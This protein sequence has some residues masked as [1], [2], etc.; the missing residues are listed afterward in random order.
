[1]KISYFRWGAMSRRQKKVMSWW[2]K[3]SKYADY[4]GIICD[5]AIR[6]GKTVSMAFSFVLWAMHTY[7]RENFAM[8]GKTIA[9]FRRN[10]LGTLKRQLKARG[11]TVTEKRTENLIVVSK[12]NKANLFYIFGGKDESSQD[13]IQG[14]TLA[15][16]FC[17]E[18][19]LMPESFVNQATARCSVE[20]S[21]FWFNCNPEGPQ[22][23][24]YLEWILKCRKRKLLYLHFTMEDN[25]TLS[26]KIKARYRSQYAGVFYERYI[27]GLWV[28]AEGLI[29][30]YF[31]AKKCCG[32]DVEGD[33]YYISV[34]YG[35]LNPCSMGLWTVDYEKETATRIREFYY[36]GRKKGRQLTDNEYYEH[37]E[38][39][40]GDLDIECVI[41]DPSAASFIAEIRKHG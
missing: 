16:L 19:A 32:G 23:W 27:R 12:G 22:H 24:F 4:N 34:D 37:L 10:V 31:D 7:E 14:M 6:S 9:S 40:A 15:G 1:M 20:G 8:C 38:E 5:G 39:L 28:V 18:V 11:Y 26:E 2:T 21:K 29:Y 41:V 25:L 33:E 17:D 13:L 35:T 3:K 36:D 30:P